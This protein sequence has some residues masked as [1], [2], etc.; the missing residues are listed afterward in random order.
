M[1][2]LAGKQDLLRLASLVLDFRGAVPDIDLLLVGAAAR[3]VL[4]SYA[5][6]VALARATYDAD[7]A[8]AVPDWDAFES[9]RRRLLASRIF[10]PTLVHH[11]LEHRSGMRTDLIPF[12]GVE[13]P[14]GS[15]VWPPEYHE[16][17]EVLG[18]AEARASA[19]EVRLPGGHI[20]HVVA[21]P[22]LAVLKVFAWTD[23]HLREPRKDAAD[24]F[25][26]LT[27][28]LDTGQDTRLYSEAAH[29]LEDPAFDYRVAGAWLAGHD[30]RALVDQHSR[31]SERII[32]KLTAVLRQESD[33]DGPLRLAGEASRR[34]LEFARRL[35][36]AFLAGLSGERTP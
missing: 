33:V 17:M 29:L 32:D 20:L 22:M 27:S 24:L 11:K 13:R 2:D 4:L 23:R 7:L 30:A 26:I 3:D 36:A 21:L 18:F 19:T 10:Q 5:H 14:D 25:D 8:F 16:V 9:L 28:Y 1:L 6:G 31:R 12:G 35:L 15:I 34:D